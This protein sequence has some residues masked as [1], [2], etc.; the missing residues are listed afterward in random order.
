MNGG[1]NKTHGQIEL[2]Y[3]IDSFE[4]GRIE[5]CGTLIVSMGDKTL[6]L[7]CDRCG[8]D[9]REL[10]EL[11]YPG[12]RWRDD[13]GLTRVRS[14]FGGSRVFWLCPVCGRRARYLY[15]KGQGFLC[16]E[17]ARFNYRIQQRTQNSLNHY[18][19]GMRLAREKLGWEPPDW[20]VPIYFSRLTPP[21]PRYMHETT[22]QRHLAQFRRYQLAYLRDSIREL[23][24][25][26]RR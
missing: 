25:L 26:K 19:D 2:A 4:T 21:R 8:Q 15:F 23:T 14:G 22:Y 12:S 24:A 3:R 13:L 16:R 17:C 1:Y 10:V 5:D 20:I 9:G 18:R 7:R 6:P 11:S